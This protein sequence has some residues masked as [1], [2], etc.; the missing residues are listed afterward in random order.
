M[1]RGFRTNPM[2]LTLD[3]LAQRYGKLPSEIIGLPPHQGRTLLFDIAVLKAGVNSES[4]QDTLKGKL[5][6]KRSGW[7]PEVI[8]EMK[9][10]G[11][12]R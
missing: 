9:E 8:R 4:S 3:A 1:T 10:E 2:I 7:D 6:S 12:W 5:K 11:M